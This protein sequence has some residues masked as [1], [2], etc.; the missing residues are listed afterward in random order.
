MSKLHPQA[1]HAAR[2]RSIQFCYSAALKVASTFRRSGNCA[3]F[4]RSGN[5]A[6]NYPE[7]PFPHHQP[8]KKPTLLRFILS[9]ELTIRNRRHHQMPNP[10]AF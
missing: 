10:N 2:S 5:C 8:L 9:L 6:S 1:R 7:S 3:T 4:R